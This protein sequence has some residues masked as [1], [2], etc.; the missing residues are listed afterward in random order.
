MLRFLYFKESGSRNP[1]NSLNKFKSLLRLLRKQQRRTL[2]SLCTAKYFKHPLSTLL[3]VSPSPHAISLSHPAVDSGRILSLT[4]TPEMLFCSSKRPSTFS[5]KLQ[6][7]GLFFSL[8]RV[9]Q[10]SQ[11]IRK[12]SL[13][14]CS[15]SVASCSHR[16]TL[17]NIQVSRS[18]CWRAASSSQETQGFHAAQLTLIP[19][20]RELV[21]PLLFAK[22]ILV[23]APWR[24]E[25]S[26]CLYMSPIQTNLHCFPSVPHPQS[27]GVLYF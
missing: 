2:Y 13:P 9:C 1:K 23:E 12:L 10:S 4:L 8:P 18:H 11:R 19:H 26:I 17:I 27:L 22:E 21:K 5:T 16:A 25:C 20:R 6:P 24:V 15:A 3:L 7:K 14:S